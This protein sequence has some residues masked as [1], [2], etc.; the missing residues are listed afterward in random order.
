MLPGDLTAVLGTANLCLLGTTQVGL[1]LP[2]ISNSPEQ[3]KQI[4]D[5]ETEQPNLGQHRP[6]H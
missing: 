5:Q 1:S 3:Q 6:G 2:Q 4:L